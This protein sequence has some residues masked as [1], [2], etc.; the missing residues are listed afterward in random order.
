MH[1]PAFQEKQ[2]NHRPIKDNS[3]PSSPALPPPFSILIQPNLFSSPPLPSAKP[4]PHT[5]PSKLYIPSPPHSILL[6]PLQ[7]SS[8]SCASFVVFGYSRRTSRQHGVRALGMSLF[9]FVVNNCFPFRM[10]IYFRR[11]GRRRVFHISYI[12]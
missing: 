4:L 3:F 11:E 1:R 2:P 12:L 5:D 8:F 7:A 9:Y 6:S 10:Y